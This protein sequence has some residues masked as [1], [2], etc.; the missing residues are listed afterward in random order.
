MY[1]F[2]SILFFLFIIGSFEG[3]T[4]NIR[5][6]FGSCSNQNKSMKHWEYINSF[7]PAYLILLGDNVYGDFNSPQAK[8]LKTAYSK[9]NKNKFFLKLRRNSV[10]LSIWDDHDYGK[11]DGSKNWIYK[12]TAKDIFL[13]FFNVNSNDQRRTREGLYFSH[14][15][16]NKIKIKTIALDTRYFKD[17]FK[18]NKNSDINKKYIP[19]NNKS[20]TILGE[21]QWKWLDGQINEEYD[22]LLILSSIQV[23]S[24]SHGWEKWHNFPHER[25]KLIQLINKTKKKTIIL[26][27]DRHIGRIYKYNNNIYEVTSSSLNQSIFN[28]NEIDEFSITDLVFSNN[29]GYMEIDEIKRIIDVELVSGFYNNRK[30]YRSLKINF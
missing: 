16:N 14:N 11:N 9:L 6:I 3:Y 24:K 29:F 19:D 27:G 2:K 30:I 20:K 12:D 5:I 1:L 25:E 18:I 4:K 23:L 28:F 26:S 22:I 8:N 13:E 17:E 10:L 15:Y 7:E 21:E